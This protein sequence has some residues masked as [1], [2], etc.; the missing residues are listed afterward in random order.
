MKQAFPNLLKFAGALALTAVI[1]FLMMPEKEIKDE[2]LNSS[3][4]FLGNKLL[5]MTPNEQR[6]DVEKDFEALREKTLEGKVSDEHLETFAVTVLNAEAEGKHLEPKQI[7]SLLAAMRHGEARQRANEEKLR[8]LGERVQAYRR[9]ED[10]WKKMIPPRA[11]A[12]PEARFHRPLYRIAPNFVVQIDSSAI[13]ELA[14]VKAEE[15]AMHLPP[16]VAVEIPEVHHIFEEITRTVPN[17]D[18][19]IGEIKMHIQIADSMKKVIVRQKKE[20][21]RM[22]D[23]LR[24][25]MDL[26]R[27]RELR[28]APPPGPPPP[29][30]PETKPEKHRKPE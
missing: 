9:F 17:L 29:P 25:V 26:N 14:A 22:A 30:P 5:A 23:S 6:G 27:L 12:M 16:A 18:I 24:Q 28:M 4:E 13:A 1:F 8:K 10:H 15:F 19:E 7:D 11:P 20:H 3:L 21:W 2:V